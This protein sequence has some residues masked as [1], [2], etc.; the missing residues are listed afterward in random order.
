MRKELRIR[1]GFTPQEDVGL[2]RS[3]RQQTDGRPSLPPG[4][5][6]R[7]VPGAG[8][9]S[10]AGAGSGAGGEGKSKAQKK[11]EK[12]KEKKRE[13]EPVASSPS[14]AVGGAVGV[15]EKKQE[16]VKD[17]WD[18]EDVRAETETRR[19]QADAEVLKLAEELE[20]KAKV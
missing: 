13:K 5:V 4:A 6:S 19:E 14:S 17:A 7:S 11:N 12:R 1:P 10:G 2:F 16:V 20:K 3:R 15:G 18:E 9:R 8:P